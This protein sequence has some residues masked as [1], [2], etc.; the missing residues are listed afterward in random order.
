VSI[1]TRS[2]PETAQDAGFQ[3]RPVSLTAAVPGRLGERC[4]G[5]E[6][7]NP[8]VNCGR[9]RDHWIGS[10]SPGREALWSAATGPGST[11]RRVTILFISVP[12]ITHRKW[13]QRGDPI[14]RRRC[15]QHGGALAAV[16]PPL[17]IKPAGVAGPGAH[18]KTITPSPH[19]AEKKKKNTSAT[20][21][22]WPSGAKRRNPCLNEQHR[23]ESEQFGGQQAP[24]AQT[25]G[26]LPL[27]H[28]LVV[29]RPRASTSTPQGNGPTHTGDLQRREGIVAAA[30]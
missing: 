29:R 6:K 14:S 17:Q 21:S 7:R 9:T 8:N 2:W 18:T 23:R 26:G 1:A 4:W 27:D 28:A 13:N 11:G 30:R 22:P 5:Q 15:D 20:A 19:H 10:E 16:R 24:A 25:A 12:A 3:R